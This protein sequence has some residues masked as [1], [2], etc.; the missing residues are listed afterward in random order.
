MSDKISRLVR[1]KF[2]TGIGQ[3]LGL[4]GKQLFHV[5]FKIDQNGDVVDIRTNAKYNLL[6]KEAKRVIGKIPKMQPGKQQNK[7]VSVIY[8][9][10]INFQVL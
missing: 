8:N 9:L 7:N 6:D 2:D 3:D 4:K 1:R 5:Q 10:P